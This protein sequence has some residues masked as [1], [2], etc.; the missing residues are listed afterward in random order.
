MSAFEEIDRIL[1]TKAN[2]TPEMIRAIDRGFSILEELFANPVYI[3]EVEGSA[4]KSERDGKGEDVAK[5]TDRPFYHAIDLEGKPKLQG[6]K[7]T[8]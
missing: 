5:R 6:A 4:D 1:L 3:S 7:L 8:D 2:N